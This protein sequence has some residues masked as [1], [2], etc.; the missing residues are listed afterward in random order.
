MDVAESV[1]KAVSTKSQVPPSKLKG[2]IQDRGTLLF[3]LLLVIAIPTSMIL[4]PA[5][6]S[7]KKTNLM[8]WRLDF[9]RFGHS[10][11]QEEKL[12]FHDDDDDDDDNN[13][14]DDNN[15]IYRPKALSV[16]D[17][18]DNSTS[19]LCLEMAEA[20]RI[21][22]K[23]LNKDSSGVVINVAA[24][25]KNGED[26]HEEDE[27]EESLGSIGVTTSVSPIVEGNKIT[28]GDDLSFDF[29]DSRCNDAIL[30]SNWNRKL[31]LRTA[32]AVTSSSKDDF[33]LRLL[34]AQNNLQK[35]RKLY[36]VVTSTA[37]NR[38]SNAKAV[39][40]IVK[41]N[42]AVNPQGGQKI[43]AYFFDDQHRL[44]EN[45]KSFN[46]NHIDG[47]GVDK[48]KA[49]PYSSYGI[50][51]D[52]E[53][54]VL[55]TTIPS[56]WKMDYVQVQKA[57]SG[58]GIQRTWGVKNDE[59]Y[60]LK[61]GDAAPSS[62]HCPSGTH[63][64]MIFNRAAGGGVEALGNTHCD[65]HLQWC[66]DN[67]GCHPQATGSCINKMQ[68]KPHCGGSCNAPWI[69][70]GRSCS[71]PSGYF[72]NSAGDCV[73]CPSGYTS[74]SGSTSCS[75][76]NECFDGTHTCD[77]NASCQD[78]DGSFNC[79]CNAGYEG[80]GFACSPCQTGYGSLS[81]GTCQEC[82][83]NLSYP[84]T[85]HYGCSNYELTDSVVCLSGTSIVY[86][87]PGTARGNDIPNGNIGCDGTVE[88]NQ[89]KSIA[90]DLDCGDG[91][92][93]SKVISI[94]ANAI[95]DC[96]GKTISGGYGLYLE[97]NGATI[98][99]CIFK[100]SYKGLEV[101]TSAVNSIIENCRIWG[102]ENGQVR[103]YA[104]HVTITNTVI[105]SEEGNN[106]GDESGGSGLIIGS[107]YNQN[108]SGLTLND[109]VV[110]N[111][112]MTGIFPN[113]IGVSYT[114][115]GVASCGAASYYITNVYGQKNID[116]K[117]A[118]NHVKEAGSPFIY[119]SC[120]NEILGDRVEGCDILEPK[121]TNECN[122]EC[123]PTQW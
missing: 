108:L 43:S 113:Y 36:V 5:L 81:G 42:N 65:N 77:P 47:C 68:S 18:T 55:K 100:E 66:E 19:I 106:V 51:I 23:S 61:D 7:E 48:K 107:Y 29:S 3:L 76:I 119:N 17:L 2:L 118:D 109:V 58:S 57:N 87:W 83:E 116:A 112:K 56:T 84:L 31:Q 82:D 120:D 8:L 35:G 53:Y 70:N 73:E 33:E 114:T 24:G 69:G 101:D 103:V 86:Q 117:A 46:N 92:Q 67:G 123:D 38:P 80:D 13:E 97:G 59:S 85:T 89:V 62:D 49:S 45:P 88:E 93:N 50:S 99:N 122:T 40:V 52:W 1:D 4:F 16:T 104:N 90:N 63:H 22:N 102:H 27:D 78:T 15:I 98:R 41:C 12:N 75:N 79:F 121:R 111:T 34:K 94:K 32:S 14:A 54:L 10:S 110:L 96:D 95:L 115:N 26:D 28:F 11:D 74:L 9:E 44:L 20:A 72:I 39:R 21:Y 64:C 25:S 37:W 30:G 60:C 6:F 105:G 71:C 91:L